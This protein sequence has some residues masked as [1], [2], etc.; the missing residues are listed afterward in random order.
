MI[1]RH[2]P[3]IEEAGRRGTQILC[4]QELFYGPYF[5]AEQQTRWY[6]L[7]ERVPEGPTTQKMIQLARRLQ[8][9]LVVPVYEEEV[10]GVYYNTA[11]VVGAGGTS[12]AKYRRTHIPLCLR[13]FWEKF[14]SRP[15]NVGYPTFQPRS[16][17]VGVY[18]CYARHF[19][20]GARAL[21]LG[22][23]EVVFIPSATTA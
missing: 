11:A 2:L 17:G 13:G 3:L 20:E 4:L 1:A 15:G 19:P 18:I 6:E 8:M 7:T 23:A 21:G 14:Y 5:P 12:L 9:A 22:G 16:G 10:S